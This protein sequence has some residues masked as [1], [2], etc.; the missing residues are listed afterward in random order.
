MSRS[1]PLGAPVVHLFI[2]DLRL[3]DHAALH[4]GLAQALAEGRP[5]LA[6]WLPPPAQ[7]TPWGWPRTGARRLAWWHS[8]AHGL[9]QG[10]ARHGHPLWC[11]PDGTTA[12]LQA[13]ISACS[14]AAVHVLEVPAP[15]ERAVL[16]TLVAWGIPVHRH[17]IGT[18][19]EAADLPF[20]PEAVPTVFTAFRQAVERA[21]TPVPGP[22]P[23]P[24]RWPAAWQPAE[25][26][27]DRLGWRCLDPQAPDD[28]ALLAGDARHALPWPPADEAPWGGEA[29]ALRHLQ[30]YLDGGHARRY[31][32]TRNHLADPWGS[33]HWSLWLATGALSPRQAL[34][35]LRAHE[36]AHGAT[37]G[38]Y[39]L[40][41]ELLWR[42]HFRWL[43]RRFGAALY[44]ARG[45]APHAPPR[46]LDPQRLA[47]WM[48]GETGC[49]IVDAGMRELAASGYLSNRMRQIVASYWLHELQGDWR[50]GAAWFEAQLLDHAPCSNTGNWLYIAGLGTDPRGGRRFDPRKQAA[51]HDPDG[52]Y[53]RRWL[54]PDTRP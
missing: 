26:I 15:E 21:H 27:A 37:D 2:A 9:A 1:L 43:H 53:R 40:W 12:T 39:W 3:H 20:T 38:T 25:N 47:R 30:R 52:A 8:A 50:V 14:P 46:P 13:W 34:A 42:D 49:D 7:P 41:F 51:Q 6:L 29:A 45:L 16:Q 28:T 24:T 4:A 10:L 11:L 19:H 17:G 48:Q 23:V 32:A 35:A 36:A 31:K 18:L 54:A 33:S 44:R 22:L 5:W